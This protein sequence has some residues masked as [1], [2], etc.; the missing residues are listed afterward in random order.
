MGEEAFDET[1]LIANGGTIFHQN[2][3]HVPMQGSNVRTRWL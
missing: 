2:E 1:I 3:R